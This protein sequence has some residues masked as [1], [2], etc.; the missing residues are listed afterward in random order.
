[1]HGG[2]EWE[3][4]GPVAILEWELAHLRMRFRQM[5]YRLLHREG[6]ARPMELTLESVVWLDGSA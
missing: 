4:Q 5:N 3:C 2:Y 6:K 1:M